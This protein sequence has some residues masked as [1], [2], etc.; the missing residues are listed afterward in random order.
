MS[1]RASMDL[2]ALLASI[3]IGALQVQRSRQ[4]GPRSFI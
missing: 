2:I 4:F 1:L 3:V